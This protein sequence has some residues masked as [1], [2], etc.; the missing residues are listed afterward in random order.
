VADG[1]DLGVDLQVDLHEVGYDHPDAV[2][3]VA[4]VQ[5]EYVVRYGGEDTTPL[6]PSMFVPPQGR[7]TVVY[8]DGEPVA[9]GGWRRHDAGRDGPVPGSRPAEIKRMY[10][11]PRARGRG[12]ARA[13]LADLERS[14]RAAGCDVMVLE[15][16]LAQPEALALYRSAGYDD[17]APFGHY[18]DSEQSVHLAKRL[19]PSGGG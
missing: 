3:L 8:L 4:E 19:G 10:V 7:Y 16:G 5:Q 9:M 12:L 13:L 2:A 14:A 1:V 18:P 6:D 11:T 17:I 15:S